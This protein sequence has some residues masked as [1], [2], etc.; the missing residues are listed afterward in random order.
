MLKKE[1]SI[2]VILASKE[3]MFISQHNATMVKNN[4]AE[5]HKFNCEILFYYG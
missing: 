4:L 3:G 5:T 2:N 1:E